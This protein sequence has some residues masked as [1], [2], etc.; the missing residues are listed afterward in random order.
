[1]DLIFLPSCFRDACSWW[2]TYQQSLSLQ[3]WDSLPQN[4][5]G[6]DFLATSREALGRTLTKR[7][8]INH[9]WLSSIKSTAVFLPS[10]PVEG[11]K[12][13]A[14]H[15]SWS[16]DRHSKRNQQGVELHKATVTMFPNVKIHLTNMWHHAGSICFV[17][18]RSSLLCQIKA[19]HKKKS[20]YLFQSCTKPHFHEIETCSWPESS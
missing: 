11:N 12:R 9:L 5:S 16:F 20:H 4:H 14:R 3:F 17:I 6:P 18:D 13:L 19:R 1:M 15:D 10:K 7:Q 8:R 2:H